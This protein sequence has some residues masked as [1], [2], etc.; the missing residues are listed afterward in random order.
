MSAWPLQFAVYGAGDAGAQGAFPALQ[1]FLWAQLRELTRVITT[2]RIAGLAQL[3]NVG[4]PSLR[5]VLDPRGRYEPHTI[6]ETNTG[7]PRELVEFCQWCERTCPADQHVLVLSGHGLAFQDSIARDIYSRGA[8]GPLPIKR[9]KSLFRSSAVGTR[10]LMM[11][12]SDFLTV[13]EMR[14]ALA[15]VASAY[16]KGRID[17]VVFDAC[18]MSNI[19]L[20]YELADIAGAAVGAV[21]EISGAG[22]NLAGAAQILDGAGPLSAAEIASAFVASYAPGKASDSCI[23]VDLDRAGLDEA[24]SAFAEFSGLLLADISNSAELARMCRDALASSSRELVRYRSKSLADLAAVYVALREIGLPA[25]TLSALEIAVR[26]FAA[27]VI[28]RRVGQDYA[29]ALG[30]SLFAP[31]SL[32]QYRT[33]AADYNALTFAHRTRWAQ[34]LDHLYAPPPSPELMA[35]SVAAAALPF[36]AYYA[37]PA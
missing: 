14:G 7:D 37:R 27:L 6:R 28:G 1:S 16:A 12:E 24:V 32:D 18:L 34:V 15:A 22:L 3:D 9:A 13:P 31:S 11:D 19:E 25:R 35:R 29:S 8:A 23:A 33:N 20:L 26:K 17:V 21:D 36:S 5:W 2:S 4:A 30:L 10:A